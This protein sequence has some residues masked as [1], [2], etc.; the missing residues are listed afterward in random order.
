MENDELNLRIQR[1]YAAVNSTIEQDITK[2]KPTVIK[3]GNRIGFYQDWSGDITQAERINYLQSLISNIAEFEY[4]LD[5]WADQSGYDKNIVN[6]AVESSIELK[7][8]HDLWNAE[9][10]AD[11]RRNSRSGLFPIIKDISGNLQLKTMPAKGSTISLTF[12]SDGT[13]NIHGKGSAKV[14]I[15]GEIYG[16]DAMKIGNFH[17]IALKAVAIWEDV[18]VKFGIKL[19]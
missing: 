12:N 10:H 8:I 4:I 2:F 18:L 5:K 6:N 19:N 13:P 15:T 17:E 11:S 7:V 9:K 1:L 14:I 16:K 3:N